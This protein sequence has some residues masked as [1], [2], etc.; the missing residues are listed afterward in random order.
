MLRPCHVHEASCC[1]DSRLLLSP[2]PSHQ[3]LHQVVA[4]WGLRRRLSPLLSLLGLTAATACSP[5]RRRAS[6]TDSS[7]CSK[8]PQGLFVTGESMTTSRRSSVMFF[9]G[10]QSHSASSTTLPTCIYLSF[11]HFTELLQSSLAQLLHRDSFLQ[12]LGQ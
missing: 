4:S 3:E 12:Y 6:W 10:C 2:A 7:R 8:P 1:V 9:T 5:E 11:F